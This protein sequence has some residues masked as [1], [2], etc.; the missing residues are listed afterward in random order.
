MSLFDVLFKN[1]PKEPDTFRQTFKMLNG[2]VPTFT[3][4]GG[5]V[6]ES[7]LIRA[8]IN[9]KATHISKLKIEI[10]GAAR[11]ALQR[12][13]KAGPNQFQTWSQF[14]YRLATILEIHNTAFITPIYDE[15]GEPSG[16]YTP[17]P[18]K[19][20]IV[21]YN[22][23]PYLRYQFGNGDHAA[24]ELAYCGIMTKHQYKSDFMGES[25][26]ALVPTMDLIHIQDQGIKEGVKSAATY[27][28]MAQLANFSK[29]DDLAKERKRFTEE[30]FASDAQGGG[31]LLFPNTYTNIKQID[32]KPWVV[33]ADQMK[34]IKE[35]VFDYF[36]VNEDVLQNKAFGDSWSAFYE[37]AIESFAIQF[38]EVMTKMLFTLR[39]QVQGNMV[40]ATANRLQY[41]S[42]NEKLNV[43][44]Q[45][46]DRGIMSINDVREIW[47]LPPVDGGDARIIR[48][49]YYNADEKVTETEV[50]NDETGS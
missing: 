3:T 5:G 44:S 39:E 28:F 22:G 33:D 41:L 12:K 29:A 19:C 38:S 31:M 34:V 46:L 24:I 6:Y 18:S 11:P 49:E 15:Y 47:N 17:L 4:R 8:A 48:G 45:M 42:N 25:N 35:N 10:T 30:N 32:V 1:S 21:Q 20:E 14:M 43:S 13:L 9:A 7:E 40:T 50:I 16:V 37:G 36:G 26:N 27:R 2:Y 23:I